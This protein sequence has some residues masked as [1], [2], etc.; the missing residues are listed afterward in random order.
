MDQKLK[1]SRYKILATEARWNAWTQ[2]EFEEVM[3]H[4]NADEKT[5]EKECRGYLHESVY[6]VAGST[7]IWHGDGDSLLLDRCFVRDQGS[8]IQKR[9]KVGL[10]PGHNSKGQMQLESEAE[11]RAMVERLMIERNTMYVPVSFLKRKLRCVFFFC[12]FSSFLFFFPLHQI[13]RS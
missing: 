4:L 12:S 1:W 11:K 2:W 7:K 8:T 13:C 3:E 6:K 10:P 5:K 9:S